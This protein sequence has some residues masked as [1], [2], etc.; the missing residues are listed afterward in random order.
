MGLYSSLKTLILPLN[1]HKS[2]ITS[3]FGLTGGQ[4]T[5]GSGNEGIDL[6]AWINERIATGDINV[7]D[8][9][10]GYTTVQGN[11]TPVASRDTINFSGPGVSVA[12]V[13]GETVVTIS[14]GSSYTDEMAQDAVG[15]MVTDGSLVYVDATPLLTR[16]ALTG[17]V[18]SP[19]G[20]NTTTIAA[21]A[22]TN[23]KL[24]DMPANTVKV[25]NA[26]TSGDP[27][28]MVVPV[29]T[30][31]GRGS[32]GD[33]VP[34][35]LGA[36]LSMS[37]GGVLSASGGG[38]GSTITT[39]TIGSARISY[40]I[41]TGTPV[42]TLPKATGTATMGVTGGT[43]KLLEVVD[44]LMVGDTSANSIRYDFIGTGANVIDAYPTTV[45]YT[46]NA[47]TPSVTTT[48]DIGDQQDTDNTPPVF[49]GNFITTGQ[50][51]MSARLNNITA[52][53]YIKFTWT[54]KS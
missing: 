15:A 23:T 51:T 42:I 29:S 22:V 39:A 5:S 9:A 6:T 30:M 7:A 31:V 1:V 26:A 14:S 54:Q 34:I 45:K 10:G 50:G 18:T 44:N 47:T 13:G 52:Q 49:Y 43:I 16:G 21:N 3:A 32:S 38:G 27:V 33:I 40:I 41:L 2:R 28:D 20:S 19:Q 8:I 25:R 48:G 35:T 11:G 53:Y 36:N 37:A 12:D 17:E 4:T 46:V 24:A